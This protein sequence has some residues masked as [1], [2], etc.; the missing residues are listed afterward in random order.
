M[1]ISNDSATVGGAQEAISVIPAVHDDVMTVRDAARSLAGFRFD[2]RQ[3]ESAGPSNGTRNERSNIKDLEG[4]REQ[5][6][7]HEIVSPTPD[8]DLAV[9]DLA[10]ADAAPADDQSEQVRG[11]TERA[12]PADLP[13]PIE[14]PRSWTKEDKEL[15]KGLPRETQQRLADRERSR[16]SDFLRRQNEAAEKLK[17]LGARE[18]AAEQARAQ[19]E[20]ALPAMLQSLHQQQA[21]EFADIKSYAD[22]ERLAREDWPRYVIWDAQQKKVA[23][24]LQELGTAQARQAEASQL[25][26]AQFAKRQDDLFQEK[27]PEVADRTQAAR[28]QTSALAVLHDLGFEEPEL[29]QL[30]NGQRTL[31]LRDHRLQLLIRDGIRYR[32]AQEKAK[33]AVAKPVPPVQRPGVA[34]PRGAVHD[35]HIQALTK[36]LNNASGINATRLAAQLVAERRKARG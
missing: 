25:Q 32:D 22:I 20:S 17:S 7:A 28:L 30:W 24:L 16:E 29:V 6:G 4:A 5:S 13:P 35:A 15:F 23:A 9:A 14:P 34:Q 18:Q 31:S 19:Y 33:Q 3:N 36:Q 12:D 2:R 8:A 10:A 11:E 27:V 26:W 21:S 1:D